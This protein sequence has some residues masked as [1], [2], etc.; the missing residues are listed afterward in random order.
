MLTVYAFVLVTGYWAWRQ[1]S[2]YFISMV[3]NVPPRTLS[4]VPPETWL[5]G[6]PVYQFQR[7]H[8]G[9]DDAAS[10]QSK[11]EGVIGGAAI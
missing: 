11:V 4:D 6:S 8:Y 7:V 1:N 3:A 9:W 10:L 2:V 5:S